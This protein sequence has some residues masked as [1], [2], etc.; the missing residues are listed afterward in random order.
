VDGETIDVACDRSRL[1]VR[2]R[3]ALV[4]TVCDAVEAAHRQLVIHR[5][6]KPS[7]VLVTADGRPM[8]L[9][10]GIA[11]TLDGE[12]RA[13]G[14]AADVPPGR[15]SDGPAGLLTPQYAAPEQVRGDAP[16][17]SVD[18]YALGLL[19]FELLTGRRPYDARG[20]TRAAAARA[21]LE[22][23]VPRPSDVVRSGDGAA[24]RAS[25]RSTTPAALRRALRGDLDA[26]VLRATARD[27]AARYGTVGALG[28]DV[29]RVLASRPVAAR[30][31]SGVQ[32]LVYRTER[33]VRRHRGL[34][35]AVVVV[36][37]AGTASAASY[38]RSARVVAAERDRAREGA[39]RAVRVRA[40]LV[41]LF[42][43]ANPD[44][45]GQAPARSPESLLRHG[46]AMADSLADQPETQADLFVAIGQAWNGVGDPHAAARAFQRAV[47]VRRAHLAADDPRLAEARRQLAGT[48]AMAHRVD[49][50]T[51]RAA[52]R[53]RGG[54][55]L[56]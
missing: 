53:A 26:I 12:E 30:R 40:A 34:A 15:A 37:A 20:R 47:E 23:H 28:A 33:L 6:L 4:A 7:N 35:A 55:A 51:A 10:F 8:L 46:E 43:A 19:L 38:V 39:T 25:A 32:K 54:G 36:V 41:S 3:L 24:E 2:A 21:V 29:R 17:V 22:A 31:I 5:D 27:P 1:G 18:V 56:P 14:D 48:L 11:A 16:S 44:Y 49:T 50:A 42:E 9:D 13:A 45:A 52:G